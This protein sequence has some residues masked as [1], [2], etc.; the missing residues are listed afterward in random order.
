MRPL[1]LVALLAAADAAARPRPRIQGFLLSVMDEG[2][3]RLD[4]KGRQVW[5]HACKPYDAADLGSGGAL[6][7]ERAA[8]RVVEVDR[9]GREVW[10]RGGLLSPT[11]ADRLPNGNTLILENGAGRVVEVD[12]HGVVVWEAGGLSNPYD[13]ERLPNGHTIVADSGNNRLV[14]FDARGIVAREFPGLAFPNSV[15]R[16]P[17]GEILFTTYT[18][19]TSGALGA[20]GRLLWDHKVG[21]TVYSAALEGDSLWVSDGTGG[22]VVKLSRDGRVLEEISLGKRFV[23][24]FFSRHGQAPGGSR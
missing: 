6:I 20:E 2:V 3:F 14:E 13:A 16:A 10:E 9:D 19:G 5:S 8:G 24:L 22:R 23:D 17:S 12:S 11:D 1:L 4:L 18:S 15:T 7:T 21:G